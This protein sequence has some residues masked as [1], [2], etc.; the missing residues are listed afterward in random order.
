MLK[1]FPILYQI[2]RHTWHCRWKAIVNQNFCRDNRSQQSK[3]RGYRHISLYSDGS[4]WWSQRM[5][6]VLGV[7]L[8]CASVT[9]AIVRP[10]S[11]PAPLASGQTVSVSSAPNTRLFSLSPPNHRF[12][13]NNSRLQQ[14]TTNSHV[15]LVYTS[16]NGCV[17]C[18]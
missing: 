2:D 18:T 11:W 12:N 16:L 15:P 7:G 8:R 4:G 6:A 3:A 14:S 13:N 17:S 9:R 1:A 10:G 5:L